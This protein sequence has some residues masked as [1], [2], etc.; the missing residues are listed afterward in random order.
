MI[1][2]FRRIKISLWFIPYIIL[3]QFIPVLKIT[4]WIFM[5]VLIHELSHILMAYLFGYYSESITI[6][7]FGIS[8]RIKD[9][10]YMNIYHAILIVLAG[11]LSHIIMISILNGACHLGM[12]SLV[13]YDYL[14]MVN[15]SMLIFNLI[16]IYP[17]DGGRLLQMWLQ[18]F[19]TYQKA[20][21]IMYQISI[22]FAIIMILI[23]K[24]FMITFMMIHLIIHNI[25][26]LKHDYIQCYEFY[27]YRLKHPMSYP[28]R[29][30][31][32]NDL[33]RGCMNVI[34]NDHFFFYEKQWIN[35]KLNR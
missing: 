34:M 16:T 12:I 33:Y 3:L 14:L 4:L 7:P 2:W 8:A 20:N 29:F 23:M 22:L 13:F 27:R 18:L 9:I 26:C 28:Y 6:Y 30:H 32:K 25:K 5:I 11:P 21:R 15:Q 1:K 31:D 24:H 35:Y 17:M 10:E 19:F